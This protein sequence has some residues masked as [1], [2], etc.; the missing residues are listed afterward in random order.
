MSRKFILS[1]ISCTLIC[2][3]SQLASAADVTAGSA[4]FGQSP[5]GDK[6]ELFAPG[7]ISNGFNNRDLAMMPDGSE[8]YSSV[9]MRNFDL[10]TVLVVKKSA[11]GWDDP[12]VAGFAADKNNRYLE[13]AISPD[14][15]RMFFVTAPRAGNDNMDIWVMDRV[16]GGWGKPGKLND[17]INTPVSETFPSITSDG[18]LYFSRVS[19]DPGVEHIYRS[20]L[21]DGN[22]SVAERL[23]ENVNCGKTQFNAFVSPDESY[24]IVSVY[25]RA[26]SLGSIDYYIVYHNEQDE[27]SEPFNLGDKINTPGAQEYSSFVSRDGKYFFFMSTRQPADSVAHGQVYSLQELTA[28]FDNPENG[29]SDIYWMDAGFIEKMRPDGF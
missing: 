3:L 13:P 15:T 26:D 9:N 8:F 11:T 7:I 27:W 18:T 24:L 29:N 2:L 19:D 12:R 1:L 10:S 16:P 22:Y 25:G 28:A 23:P 6:A 17:V 21:V 5:P 4:Y 20:R 14:G